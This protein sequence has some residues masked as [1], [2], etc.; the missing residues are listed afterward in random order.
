ME[1]DDEAEEA[2]PVVLLPGSGADADC[3]RDGAD[4]G[5]TALFLAGVA[6]EFLGV[7]GVREADGGRALARDSA[8]EDKGRSDKKMSQVA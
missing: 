5:D 8:S 4:A 3:V 7:R 6:V 1:R 2:L